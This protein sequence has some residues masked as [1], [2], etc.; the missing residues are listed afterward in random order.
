MVVEEVEKR[1]GIVFQDKRLLLQALTHRS[2][3]NENRVWPVGHNERFEFLGDAVLELIV[4]E[5]LF[6]KYPNKPEGDMTNYRAALVCMETNAK[7][8]RILGLD[9]LILMS[10]GEAKDL[11]RARDVI[12]ADAFEALIGALYLDQGI[13]A[14]EQLVAR[15]A[16]SDPYN[17][18][19]ERLRGSNKNRLQEL[20]QADVKITPHYTTLEESG[21][22]HSK[23]FV[24]GVFFGST[25]IA[26]GDG[27]SKKRAEEN[28]AGNALA[29]K[30][31]SS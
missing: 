12:L 3:L 24:V 2:Y 31:W 17:T 16:L 11:G 25:M 15:T 10:R 5:F 27:Q 22:E 26:K 30:G 8:A 14:V 13:G 29:A 20:A 18:I 28:A 7:S 6:M 9:T 19:A 1:I 23:H 4:T 21:P